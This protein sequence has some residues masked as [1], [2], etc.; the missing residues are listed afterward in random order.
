MTLHDSGTGH[1]THH[2]LPAF[3]LQHLKSLLEGNNQ[4]PKAAAE[5]AALGSPK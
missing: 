2:A 1:C 3:Q 4:K 5:E